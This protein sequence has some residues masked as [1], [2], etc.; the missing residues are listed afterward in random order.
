MIKFIFYLMLFAF[1]FYTGIGQMIL[2]MI[3]TLIM[4]LGAVIGHLGGVAL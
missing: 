2:V 3:G 4:M 1:L